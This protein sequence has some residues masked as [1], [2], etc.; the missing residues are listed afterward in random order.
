MY[1][2]I[3]F[4]NKNQDISKTLENNIVQDVNNNKNEQKPKKKFNLL[5]IIIV[6]IILYK[7]RDRYN[8]RQLK[9]VLFVYGIVAFI[10]EVLKQFIWSFNYDV[11]TGV[12]FWDYEWYAFPFQLCTTP[13]FVC[14]ICLFLKKYIV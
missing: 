4:N 14:L 13:I 9:L 5:L 11:L 8:E 12:I 10:L 7:Y 3:L 6:L 2:D 1:N